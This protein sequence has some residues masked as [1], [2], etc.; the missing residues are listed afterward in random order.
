MS[1]RTIS[2][3]LDDD[4]SENATQPL[5][6]PS[7]SS[8]RTK[9]DST[10]DALDYP[11]IS[12]AVIKQTPFQQPTQVIS[13]SYTPSRALEFDDSALR[14]YVD[15][16]PGAK[17]GH[18][19]QQW[20][21]KPDERGRID[22]L[23]QAFA[24]AQTTSGV[25]LQDVG[26]VAWRGVMTKDEWE[27]NVMYVNGTLYF[28]EHL[29]EER[30]KQK[31]DIEP[32][33]RIQTYYGYSFESY[34]TSQT[35]T[36]KISSSAS[37]PVG[38]GGDVDTNVQWCSVVRTKLGNTRLLIGG[39]VDC[40]RERYTHQTD[41]FVEL[42]TS[43]AIRGAHD[44]AKFEK[45]LLKFYFQ[46]FLLG[47]PEI[48]VGF[49]TP[50]GV[51][52]TTQ[53]FKT[54]QLPRLVRGKPGAWDPLI[55]LAWGD[56]VITFLKDVVRREICPDASVWRVKFTP[57]KGIAVTM[58]DL[59][60]M[61]DVRGGEDRVGFL[62]TWYWK[63][64]QA[65][66]AHKATPAKPPAAAPGLTVGWQ[67]PDAL[68]SCRPHRPALNAHDVHNPFLAVLSDEL[69]WPVST[70]PSRVMATPS[71]SATSPSPP[72]T[73]IPHP[74][75]QSQP[76]ASSFIDS[77]D[78]DQRQRA[79]QKF[80]ARAEI[81]TAAHNI[82]HVPLRDLE[83]H[84][85][86]Q[87]QTAS[88][89]RTI[90]AKRKAT[91]NNNN[92]YNNPATQ[93]PHGATTGSSSLRRGG[94]G[95]ML[96]PS[97]PRT[98]YPAVNGSAYATT[99]NNDP[100]FMSRPANPNQ[101][102]YTSILAPPPSKQAR[103]IH[104]AG[105][106]PVAASSRPLASPRARAPKRITTDI[107]HSQTKSR[108]L[109]H[110][111]SPQS[112][113]SRKVKRTPTDKGKRKQ[114]GADVDTETGGDVDM[115]AAATLTSLLMHHRPSMT[116]SAS[117]PRSSIDG[118]EAGSN[119]SYSHFAQSS[120]RTITAASPPA[121]VSAAASTSTV[122][123]ASIRNH[124]PPP[125]ALAPAP[126]PGAEKVTTPRPAPTDSEAANLMLFLAT[127]PSPARPTNTDSRD[128]AAY[129]ALGGGPPGVLRDKGRVLFASGSGTE[130]S[131]MSK[132]P[133]LARS[134]DASF[135]S[136]ISS[137]GGELGGASSPS[138]R[139]AR[140][141]SPRPTYP[142]GPVEFNF[143]DFIHGSPSPSRGP[144]VPAPKANLGLRAD[145]GRKLFEEEQMRHALGGVQSPGKRPERALG[146]G[147]D[148][149][150]S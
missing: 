8:K 55:C 43:L 136:S 75:A 122:T 86:N 47:V 50:S 130:P 120:A 104:N 51:V 4:A 145:V 138:T 88:F 121:P 70:L 53:S 65:A 97:S 9:L 139:N 82:H 39:E 96:P 31:N 49:R 113:N 91:G 117:S 90:A 93:N 40:V 44:E 129:R 79:V 22:G 17:L 11:D 13:F 149:V 87:S 5:D 18:G 118:S 110:G 56:Q 125:P 98:Y 67:L 54:I 123:E 107:G 92:Y 111:A 7:W 133:A 32:R 131:V 27:L 112:S 3:L 63:E 73:F 135:T 26:V 72:M 85:Q 29:S 28:E 83:A 61:E 20:V 30:L 45:K 80:M 35:P 132:A 127:S 74:S 144:V 150:Q 68:T 143:N 60:D 52:T 15:P 137:I 94:S 59:V 105:D 115:K 140:N 23:L 41:T 78:K 36:R 95:S 109:D 21:R 48:V 106:P 114:H 57:R 77:A 33:H 141:D 62:P 108:K 58:L 19:Y 99:S 69:L 14:F 119:Y 1:K 76:S 37:D 34:C 16:P 2:Q 148:L 89:S 124:T 25:P 12:K 146:A 126:P 100:S 103:T 81:S 38:W 101:S 71:S 42:K 46:S 142:Q 24:K 64:S 116:G 134:G 84:S 128:L 66:G 10:T 6:G 147:I 102:L